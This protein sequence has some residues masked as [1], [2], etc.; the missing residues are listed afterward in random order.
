MIA[1]HDGTIHEFRDGRLGIQ[2][3]LTGPD[4]VRSLYAHLDNVTASGEVKKG[5]VIAT[6]GNTGAGAPDLTFTLRVQQLTCSNNK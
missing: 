4:G 6:C 2:I 1:V 5:D 3:R